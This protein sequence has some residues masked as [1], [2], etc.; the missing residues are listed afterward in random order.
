ML[1]DL[2][3]IFG[4][5]E[6]LSTEA[7][8]T[9][10]CAIEES[11]WADLRGKPLDPRGLARRL[12]QY[13]IA[14]VKVK[15]DGKALKGYRREHLWDAWERY[16]TPVQGEPGE[17]QEPGRSEDSSEVPPADPQGEP[18]EPSVDQVPL[19][20]QQGEPISPVLSRAVPQVPQVPPNGTR[21]GAPPLE[22]DDF[23]DGENEYVEELV[24][25]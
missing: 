7:V 12:H 16:L 15:V 22:E 4:E 3:T 24:T 13:E 17:P 10:L 2:R 19:P 6:A 20:I 1:T 8:L 9:G 23:C 18:T 25:S 5:Q 11:P 21:D 14:P